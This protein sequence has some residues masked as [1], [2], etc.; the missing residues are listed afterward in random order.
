MTIE[1]NNRTEQE[2][3]AVAGKPRDAAVNSER[4]LIIIIIII[5]KYMYSQFVLFANFAADTGTV[6]GHCR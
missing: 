1:F 3:H 2:S 5:I 6:D 4:R